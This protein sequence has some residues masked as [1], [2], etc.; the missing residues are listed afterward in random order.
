MC[1]GIALLRGVR[2]YQR[3]ESSRTGYE[4]V[5]LDFR[6]WF[7]IL[8][9]RRVMERLNQTAEQENWGCRLFL[10][11]IVWQLDPGEEQKRSTL[12]KMDHAFRWILRRFVDEEWIDRRLNESPNTH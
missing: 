8:W 6:D 10:D 4:R 11:G 2:R 1:L 5:W 9:T 12:A 7:G 3:E